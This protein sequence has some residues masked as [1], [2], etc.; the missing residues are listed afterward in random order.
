MRI[1]GGPSD[2]EKAPDVLSDEVHLQKRGWP[3]AEIYSTT[4]KLCNATQASPT[5]SPRLDLVVVEGLALLRVI[6]AGSYS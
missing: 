5:G 1:E 2:G 4:I 3:T 6:R